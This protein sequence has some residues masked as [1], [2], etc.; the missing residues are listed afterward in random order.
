MHWQGISDGASG[1]RPADRYRL[2]WMPSAYRSALLGGHV[3]VSSGGGAEAV[4]VASGRYGSA[5][6]R[7]W[8]KPVE[9]AQVHGLT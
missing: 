5:V 7:L 1:A 9:F 3:I 8:L 2:S 6:S 4:A